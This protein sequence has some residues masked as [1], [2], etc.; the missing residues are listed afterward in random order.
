M[1][2]ELDPERKE[3]MTNTKKQ[4]IIE[5]TMFNIVNGTGISGK[6]TTTLIGMLDYVIETSTDK[7]RV[8]AA[9]FAKK[10]LQVSPALSIK[11]RKLESAGY[12]IQAAMRNYDKGLGWKKPAGRAATELFSAGTNIAAPEYIYSLMDQ[13]DFIMNERY[14]F[15][16]QFGAAMGWSLYSMDEN[17]Y[18]NRKEQEASEVTDEV[19]G[20]QTINN[21][22][23]TGANKGGYQGGVTV[24]S[25]RKKKPLEIGAN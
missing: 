16:Q 1:D 9:E 10:S 11:F 22:V 8:D 7:K 12:D 13:Y 21:S 19:D 15:W 17:F 24:G 5:N 20:Y 3:K 23:V 25:K 6:A 18:K 2:D 14:T 4:Q